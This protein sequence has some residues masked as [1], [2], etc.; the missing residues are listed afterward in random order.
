[1]RHNEKN[2]RPLY[3]IYCDESCHLENDGCKSMVLGAIWCPDKKKNEIF[4][5]LREIKIEHGLSPHFELKW[6][7]VSPGQYAYYLDV[8]N[9]F[10]TMQTFTSEHWSYQTN[11]FWIIGSSVKPMMIS[12]TKCILTC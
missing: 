6:N 1:M 11:R 4:Q 12:I 2:M 3:N 9:Y 7:A 5:R 10:S 8:I